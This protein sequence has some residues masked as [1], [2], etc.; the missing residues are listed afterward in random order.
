M[1]IIIST[2][3]WSLGFLMF[4]LSG[5]VFLAIIPFEKYRFRGAS[6]FSRMVLWGV[7]VK[8]KIEGT[9]PTDRTFVI[10]ANHTTLLDTFIVPAVIKGRFTGLMAASHTRYP[11]WGAIVRSFK[12]IPVYRRDSVAAL[13]SIDL[14]QERLE[15][16]MH[17]A[18]MP[19]GTRSLTG[20]LGRLKKGGFHMAIN[21]KVPILTFGIAGGYKIKAKHSW[22]LRPGPVYVRIGVPI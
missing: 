3:R 16:G 18:I 8:L 19:E 20:K 9:F 12:I 10:M 1:Q 2:F 7:G 11:F 5:L 22:L 15:S 17:V 13:Q 14:A 6:W 4:L 21:S